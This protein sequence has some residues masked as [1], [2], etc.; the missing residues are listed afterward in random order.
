MTY[1]RDRI[2]EHVSNL[3]SM[4]RKDEPIVPFNF[5][6][7]VV[8]KAEVDCLAAF[9]GVTRTRVLIDLIEGALP[10]AI[11]VVRQAQLTYEGKTID[12]ALEHFRS[13]NLSLVIDHQEQAA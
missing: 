2:Y 12:E 5:K 8:T 3:E 1:L 10:E 7:S 9:F 11:N 13:V 6:G 4:A